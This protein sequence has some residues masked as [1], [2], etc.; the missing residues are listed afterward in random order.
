MKI[1]NKL[2]ISSVLLTLLISIPALILISNIFVSS[3]N[4]QHLVDTVLFTYIYNSLYIMVGVAILTSLLGFTT[5]YI[6]T[7][8]S[9]KGSKFFHYALILPF[10][11]PTYIMSY[12]YGGMF[13]ITGSVT[14]FILDFMGKSFDEVNFFDIMSIEGAIIIMSLVLYPYVYL[15]SKTYLKAESSSIIDASRTMGLTNFQIF[16][17]VII[18]I[19]RPAIVAG[20]ILAVMEA[21]ADFGVMDYYGVSTFVTGIFRTWLGMG[22]VEDASKLASLL[23]LF[24]FLLIFAERFQRR[25]KQY[26]SSGKD[27]KPIIKQKLKGL[28]AFLAFLVCFIPFFLGFLLPFSQMSYWFY[29]SYE[30]IIDEDFLTI[31]FQTLSLGV[32]SSILITILAFVITYNVRVHKNKIAENLVQISK[33]GYSIPGAVVAVGIL[34]FFSIIDRNLDILLS[35]T[36]V[37]IIFGYVVRFIAISINNYESGFSKIPKTYDDACKTMQIGSFQTFFKMVFPL[38]RGSIM[39]SFIIVF[40]EVM[41]ELPLTMILRPFNFDTLPVLSHELVN[42]SQIIESSVPA[43]FIVAFGIISVLILAK[44]MVK[45]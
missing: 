32:F 29:I 40:I 14:T 8:Y 9:F 45:D 18:P 42:Q 35:G 28:K 26:N 33:L 11:I 25:N 43:M 6:T 12:I 31:L 27:F 20:V 44:K 1:F 16:Y 10:A 15:I 36:I 37:A 2:T 23:M 24:I 34:S 39:V 3:K 4:W 41:K 21:V 30:E 22:S 19:S 5:A 38:I 17:K 13:D 7:F